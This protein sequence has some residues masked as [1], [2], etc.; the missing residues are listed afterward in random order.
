MDNITKICYFFWNGASMPWLNTL[1]VVS[2][3]KYNPDWEIVIYNMTVEH[4][5]DYAP[6]YMNHTGKDYFDNLRDLPYVK[7]I[8]D[9]I[10]NDT[11]HSILY[12]DIWRREIL[13]KTGGVYS[14]FDMIWLRPI[15]H[16]RN[17]ECIGDPNNFSSLV[18]FHNYTNG[19]HNV[20][21]LISEK[22]SEFD[23]VI[24][25]AQ[26]GVTKLYDDQAFGTTLLNE[27]YP[28]YEDI[29]RDFL[30]ILAVKYETFYPYSTYRLDKLY[31]RNDL[32]PLN[33]N[34]MI[35]IHW[36]CGNP[37]SKMFINNELYKTECSMNT[38]LKQEGY[39]AP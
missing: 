7:I 26:G 29:Q 16:I 36:F 4:E 33:N 15:G 20:S 28:T 5:P 10:P 2:F 19:F 23:K 3:H 25:E 27:L 9:K 12:S 37:L 1:S 11:V 22:G 13:Y 34:N 18:S 31:L 30:R 38:I 35:G 32:S 6:N 39:V 24:I 14:D 8:E 21:N 17:V